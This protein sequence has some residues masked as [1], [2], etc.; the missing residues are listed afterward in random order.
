MKKGAIIKKIKLKDKIY[1]FTKRILVTTII[2]TNII[3]YFPA[4]S[5]AVADADRKYPATVPGIANEIISKYIN[6]IGYGDGNV[7]GI[8][9]ISTYEESGEDWKSVTEVKAQNGVTRTYRNYKQYDDG[10]TYWNYPYWGGNIWANG[11]GPVSIAIALSGYRY[12]ISPVDVVNKIEENY[13]NPSILSNTLNKLNIDNK[14]V[15]GVG[16]GKTPAQTAIND[17]KQ[18]LEN[19]RPVLV[20]I[21]GGTKY[22]PGEH[23][24]TLIGISENTITVSNPGNNNDTDDLTNFV[25]NCLNS[26][27]LITEEDDNTGSSTTSNRNT[28]TASD[29]TGQA[30]TEKS[31]LQNTG[32][33]AIFTSGTTGRQFKEYKQNIPGWDSKY[34]INHLPN[35]NNGWGGECGLVSTMIVGSGY[36]EKATFEDA[37]KKMESSGGSTYISAWTGEYTGQNVNFQ[38]YD[39]SEMVDKLSKGCVAI[40]H[41]TSGYVST[42]GTHY[43][44][45]LDIKSD[46]SE[47]YVSN[48]AN[49]SNYQGWLSVSTVNQ[50]F[51][52]D[53][54]AYITNDGSTVNYSSGA[55]ATL[56]GFLFIGDSRTELIEDDL[57]NLGSNITAKGVSGS[58]PSDWKDVIKAGSGTVCKGTQFATNFTLPSKSEVKGV[59]IALGVNDTS[60]I[61]DMKDCISNLLERYPKTP[62]FV[63]SVFYVGINHEDIWKIDATTMNNNI[64]KLNNEI[65]KFCSSNSNL[66]YI[67]ITKDLH[68]NNLLKASC[69]YDDLHLNDDGEK[70]L[71]ENIKNAILESGQ[72]KTLNI[73]NMSRNIVP[74]NNGGY[75]I[76]INIEEEVEIMLER[77]KEEDYDI[78]K[79]LNG[80]NFAK[81]TVLKN[82]L[83][84]AIVTQYPDLRTAAEIEAD[85]PILSNMLGFADE[86]QGCVKFKRYIDDETGKSFVKSSLTNPKDDDDGMYLSYMPYEDFINLINN[87]DATAM[88]HFTMDSSNNIVVAGWETMDVYF[89]EPVQISP[90][91]RT[92]P[93]KFKD[94]GMQ[95]KKQDPYQKMTT[96]SINYLDQISGYNMPFSLLW[97][98]LVYGHDQSFV[99]DLAQLVIDTEIVFGCYDSTT[100]T[101]T[102]TEINYTAQVLEEITIHVEQN[103][104]NNPSHP[105]EQ[106]TKTQYITYEFKMKEIDTLKTD[107]PQL[108]LNYADTWTAEYEREY[109]QEKD[110][111]KTETS[112]TESDE[113]KVLEQDWYQHVDDHYTGDEKPEDEDLR[114]EVDQVVDEESE[115]FLKDRLEKGTSEANEYNKKFQYRYN[116]LNSVIDEKNWYVDSYNTEIE[117][118]LKNKDIQNLMIN[119]IISGTTSIDHVKGVFNEENNLVVMRVKEITESDEIIK[120]GLRDASRLQLAIEKI[121]NDKDIYNE[122]TKNNTDLEHQ[123]TY[124]A[125]LTSVQIFE[126][127]KIIYEKETI[128]EETTKTEI[129]ELSNNK[130]KWKTNVLFGKNNFVRLLFFS[131]YA[132]NNLESVSE[133]FFDSMEETAEIADLVDLIKYLLQCTYNQDYGISKERADELKNLFDPTSF[134]SVG[135]VSISGTSLLSEFLKCWENH[136]VRN[137]MIGTGDY[138]SASKYVTEDKKN[139][140]MFDDGYGTMNFGFGVCISPNAGGTWYH[141]DKFEKLGIDITDSKYHNYNTSLMPVEIVDAVKEM[142]IEDKRNEVRNTANQVGVK[143]EDYQVDALAACR[144]QGHYI[145]NFLVAYKQYGASESIR[146]NCGGMRKGRR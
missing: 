64:D 139:Y 34:K 62:I 119:M 78:S 60:Q 45:I 125:E 124:N 129:K 57:K 138:S 6:T 136:W 65:K 113:E 14:L 133:W 128:T 137:Y 58:K 101:V 27:I 59:S 48:P 2:T 82:M 31:N 93:Q 16:S 75:K 94:N 126:Y 120:P 50:Y 79:Y 71:V 111:T 122:V 3:S 18:N 103:N 85:A 44:A 9:I 33:D 20:G 118:I 100:V 19:G 88:N 105:T 67:D 70:I 10:N 46:K 63:N 102:T 56:D 8:G 47:V 42:G 38:K 99:N 37:T 135:I 35:T 17:I 43:M 112:T 131:K 90:I 54:I 80:W 86:V 83:K 140:I 115:K 26:Y 11:C 108:K 123:K 13:T 91:D 12:D 127:K 68:E 30:S 61:Q 15:T 121:I 141:T 95:K 89:E 87:G 104:A 114:E 73:V 117:K 145:Y 69:T 1:G 97:T 66:T 5:F 109:K 32:Y 130:V 21:K 7:S 96:V 41:G 25:T 98:L 51:G 106:E 40:I 28:Y 77:L 146:T 92:A 4:V 24:M 110:E 81:K 143:L 76:D 72:I 29:K 84:A 134:N 142:V 52:A 49:G 132:K 22:S 36:T 39:S 107:N 116:A 53:E 55:V 144:Y 23:W 74:K